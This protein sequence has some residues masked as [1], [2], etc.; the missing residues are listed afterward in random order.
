MPLR[1]LLTKSPKEEPS[2]SA[3]KKLKGEMERIFD[4]IVDEG[5]HLH[6]SFFGSTGEWLPAVDVSETVEEV[7]V[8]A[9]L[10]GVDPATLDVT[11][12]GQTLAIAGEKKPR[13][14]ASEEKVHETGCRYG[15]FIRRVTLPVDV[16][17]SKTDATFAN[18]VLTLHIAK[19]VTNPGKRIDIQAASAPF[20]G[21]DPLASTSC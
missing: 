6:D 14:L 3:V 9:E 17:D 10:P 15:C 2:E 7:I 8:I 5:V 1:D 12:Q 21:D 16:D 11:I 19:V 20:P 4:R 13:V 18:G